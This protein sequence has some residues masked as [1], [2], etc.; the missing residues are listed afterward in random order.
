LLFHPAADD[1]VA[2]DSVA[3]DIGKY[4]FLAWAEVSQGTE[5]VRDDYPQ[6]VEHSSWF[7]ELMGCP[8]G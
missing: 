5:L 8:P 3:D 6:L 7:A 2:D 1:S 4:H